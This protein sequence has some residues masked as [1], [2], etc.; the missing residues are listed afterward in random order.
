MRRSLRPE[1]QGIHL[2]TANGSRQHEL[3]RYLILAGIVVKSYPVIALA[4]G[5]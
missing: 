3:L 4:E 1:R 5:P 2:R